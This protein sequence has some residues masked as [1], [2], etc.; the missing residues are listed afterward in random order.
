MI[1]SALA[2]I[3]S[4]GT[5]TGLFIRKQTKSSA[6]ADALD[7]Y[8]EAMTSLLE[9][10]KKQQTYFNDILD[11]KTRSIKERDDIIEKN[12]LAIEDFRSQIAE[13]RLKV[14]ENE[15]KVLGM[16]KII[17]EEIKRRNFAESNI[18]FVENCELRRPKQGTY[19]KE[20]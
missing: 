4:G 7:K 3:L 8:A 9:A 16:Q 2:G 6:T 5:L 11:E 19:K 18:C 17:D 15:R 1:V 13:L 14:A 20:A 10:T 12:R